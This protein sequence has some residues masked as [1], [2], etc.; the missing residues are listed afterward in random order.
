[1]PVKMLF[2]CVRGLCISLDVKLF[3]DVL[4]FY[5]LSFPGKLHR[6]RGLCYPF[7]EASLNVVGSEVL[8]LELLYNVVL[9]NSFAFFCQ[10]DF[11][12]IDLYPPLVSGFSYCDISRDI[13][14]RKLFRPIFKYI[15]KPELRRAFS[16]HIPAFLC[17]LVRHLFL[18]LNFDKAFLFQ[19]F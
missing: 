11:S 18:L 5:L 3:L 10:S 4:Y 7:H 2:S 6:P 9:F 8:V 14:L 13:D 12:V 19:L 16:Y 1:M 17:E 15:N